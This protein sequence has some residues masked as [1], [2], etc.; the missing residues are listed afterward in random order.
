MTGMPPPTL[1][2][3]PMS[4]PVAA[5]VFEELPSVFGQQGLVSRDH[6][7]ACVQ[8]L[9]Q[10]RARWLVP[11]HQFDHDVDLGIVN[12]GQCITSYL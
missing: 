8:S 4:R 7:L 6:V 1:A 3:N 11:A 9:Q 10:E 5:A 2:S 12:Y